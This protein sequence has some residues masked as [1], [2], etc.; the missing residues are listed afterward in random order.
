MKWG[1]QHVQ[2]ASRALWDSS[3]ALGCLSFR[4]WRAVTSANFEGFAWSML[5]LLT[6]STLCLFRVVQR[7]HLKEKV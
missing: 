7:L 5:C 2:G 1:G 4:V 6:I 3:M